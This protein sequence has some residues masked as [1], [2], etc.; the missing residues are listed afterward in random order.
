MPGKASVHFSE[1]AKAG[2]PSLRINIRKNDFLHE[3]ADEMNDFLAWAEE[4][5]PRRDLVAEAE[6]RAEQDAG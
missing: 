5:L 4:H 2:D 1:A 3:L 6:V